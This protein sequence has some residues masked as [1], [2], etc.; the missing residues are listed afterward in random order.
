MVARAYHGTV[1]QAKLIHSTY[2]YQCLGLPHN[3]F[4]CLFLQQNIVYMAPISVWVFHII[5]LFVLFVSFFLNQ[6]IVYM[7]LLSLLLCSHPLFHHHTD[8]YLAKSTNFGASHSLQCS[9]SLCCLLSLMSSYLLHH[10]QSV[11]LS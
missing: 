4:V 2:S 6:N 8:T 10:P 1:L 11:F 7:A 9:P 3:V 5:S